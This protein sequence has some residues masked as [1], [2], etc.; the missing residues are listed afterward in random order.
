MNIKHK[1]IIIDNDLA[2]IAIIF[3]SL[4]QHHCV[5]IGFDN[6]VAAGYVNT[7]T[8]ECWGESASLGITS[9]PE[10]SEILKRQFHDEL[11]V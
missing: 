11:D 4:I 9:R 7:T 1:Y 3:P 10:D 2:E 6:V 8:W 5:S